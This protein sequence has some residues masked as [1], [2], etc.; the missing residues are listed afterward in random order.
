MKRN[1]SIILII[2]LSSSFLGAIPPYDSTLNIIQNTNGN[3]TWIAFV[4]KMQM[5]KTDALPGIRIVHLGDSHIQGGYFTNEVRRLLSQQYSPAD[6]GWVFPYS[7]A[8]TNGPEDLSVQSTA[9]WEGFKYNHNPGL[10]PTPISGYL[11]STVDTVIS[12][13]LTLKQES[14]TL[15]PFKRLGIY[16]NS[17]NITV[18]SSQSTNVETKKLAGNLYVTS[19]LYNN[20]QDSV[21]FVIHTHATNHAFSLSGINLENPN[22]QLTYHAIGINGMAY[23]TYEKSIVYSEIL[24]MLH[25]DCII[26]SLGT[27]D[28][29]MQLH[30]TAHFKKSVA[31]LIKH[32]R[33][34]IPDCCIILTTAGDHLKDKK[35]PNPALIRINQSI[36][37][38][39]Q[40]EACAYWDFFN[41]MGGLGSSQ[42]WFKKGYFCRDF[43]HL[44]K[45]GYKL[46]GRLFF[47][48]FNKAIIHTQTHGMGK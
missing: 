29:F 8:H 5:H 30:D 14:L 16:H 44:S 12:F 27:N 22:S 41:I 9:A 1:I 3:K 28:A 24:G 19:L 23:I 11:L 20:L 18:T 48:A 46:Q 7:L 6:R 40:N 35:Y 2:L 39:A 47:E 36:I 37:E 34:V 13:K 21:Q 4:Q 25:P 32:I 43:V 45:E 17:P 33:K 31:T 15:F 26:L 38:V 42:N 10:N